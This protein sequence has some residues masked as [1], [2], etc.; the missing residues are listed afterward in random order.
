MPDLPLPCL[1]QSASPCDPLYVFKRHPTAMLK[2][3]HRM[4]LQLQFMPTATFLPNF[5]VSDA[6]I[7]VLERKPTFC[8]VLKTLICL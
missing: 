7:H 8:H 6:G 5:A 1:R 3:S 4:A 2:E